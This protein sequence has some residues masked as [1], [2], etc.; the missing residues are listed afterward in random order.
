MN[1]ERFAPPRS[2]FR[3]CTTLSPARSSLYASSTPSILV[4]PL[5]SP[6]NFQFGSYNAHV[7]SSRQPPETQLPRLILVQWSAKCHID[8]RLRHCKT[9][10]PLFRHIGIFLPVATCSMIRFRPSKQTRF[11]SST[12]AL[13][14]TNGPLTSASKNVMLHFLPQGQTPTSR[15]LPHGRR[16]RLPQP[17]APTSS[18]SFST[19]S[20]SQ[21][22]HTLDRSRINGDL[23]HLVHQFHITYLCLFTTSRIDCPLA[24]H[25]GW[26]AST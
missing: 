9:N 3:P 12:V 25:S 18:T 17:V 22:P 26:C 16:F 14:D 19:P 6:P 11:P 8:R 2:F 7:P 23:S 20:P 10:T 24:P 13:S 5:T 15:L 21:K 1:W 4:V